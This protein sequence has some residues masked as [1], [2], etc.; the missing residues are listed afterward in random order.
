MVLQE[1][2]SS[3]NAILTLDRRNNIKSRRTKIRNGA[4]FCAIH[5]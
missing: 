2:N 1:C 5:I 3:L 4:G